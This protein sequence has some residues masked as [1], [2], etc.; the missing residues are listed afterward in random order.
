[1]GNTGFNEQNKEFRRLHWHK[2]KLIRDDCG[3]GQKLFS[4]GKMG[5][6][7]SEIVALGSV[8]ANFRLKK[9]I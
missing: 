8:N 6:I 3:P 9:A 1:M 2:F 5:V 4:E 7:E